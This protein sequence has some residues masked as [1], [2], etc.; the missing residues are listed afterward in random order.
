MGRTNRYCGEWK[1]DRSTAG[2]CHALFP[3]EGRGGLFSFGNATCCKKNR[4]ISG[5]TLLLCCERPY[6]ALSGC[7]VPDLFCPDAGAAFCYVHSATCRKR[8]LPSKPSSPA[9]AGPSSFFARPSLGQPFFVNFSVFSVATPIWGLPS[10]P[11]TACSSV[12]VYPS[13]SLMDSVSIVPGKSFRVLQ[14]DAFCAQR[15]RCG[16]CMAAVAP[17]AQNLA[18][19]Q[20]LKKKIFPPPFTPGG[21]GRK[22]DGAAAKNE[23]Q[24]PPLAHGPG[25]RQCAGLAAGG[26][27][28]WKRSERR[29]MK[30]GISMSSCSPA[31][32]PGDFS[33]G[34]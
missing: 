27:S 26:Y 14:K 28:S 29:R 8:E 31:F 19:P 23:G 18:Q 1:I 33:S 9:T 3:N 11:I 16:R 15:W 10:S 7:S 34:L 24:K 12:S 17:N 5:K 25:R 4:E 20:A 21:E 6:A 32:R 22:A 2:D 30:A 13:T